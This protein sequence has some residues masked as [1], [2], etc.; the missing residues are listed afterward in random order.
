MLVGR[1]TRIGRASTRGR[2][3]ASGRGPSLAHQLHL[4][5]RQHEPLDGRA[6]RRLLEPQPTQQ[7]AERDRTRCQTVNMTPGPAPPGGPK[8][9]G[10]SPPSRPWPAPP[11][12]PHGEPATSAPVPPPAPLYTLVR[13]RPRRSRPGVLD[14][15]G[16]WTVNS[17][18]ASS[19]RPRRGRDLLGERPRRSAT[20]RRSAARTAGRRR[21]AASRRPRPG[22]GGSLSRWVAS[23]PAGAFSEHQLRRPQVR[24]AT[25][26]N[27]V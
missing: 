18:S 11:S 1:I 8:E 12:P 3:R 2:G 6:S 20:E 10:Q 17:A 21:G 5:G 27:G 24:E 15:A 4:P 23:V 16:S 14:A 19:S 26:L 9:R 13:C 7:L 22:H 25:P